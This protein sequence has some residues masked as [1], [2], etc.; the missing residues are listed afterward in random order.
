VFLHKIVPGGADR[1]YGIHVSRLAGVP[2]WVNQRADQI[3]EKLE[4]TSD[5][6]RNQ[7]AIA[8][9]D[10]ALP[11]RQANGQIQ[12]TMFGMEPHPLLDKIRSL[13]PTEM[14]PMSALEMLHQWQQELT[15]P[16]DSDDPAVAK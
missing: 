11:S 6:Q 14:T 3:L 1:S 15:E 16:A 4:S 8:S 5:V 7:E 2:N 9:T 12:L 13:E 10:T